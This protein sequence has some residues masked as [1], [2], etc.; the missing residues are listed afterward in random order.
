MSAALALSLPG[1]PVIHSVFGSA[2]F[3]APADIIQ[4]GK[5][6]SAKKKIKKK[7]HIYYTKTENEFKVASPENIEYYTI[8]WT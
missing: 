8:N 1:N 6:L 3:F 2:T 7:I 4:K 5:Q